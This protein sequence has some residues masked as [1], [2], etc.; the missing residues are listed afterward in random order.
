MTAGTLYEA[1]AQA[2]AAFR[3]QDWVGDIGSGF[4]T[5]TVKVT[6]VVKLRD[7]ENWLKAKG[8][9]PITGLILL[10]HPDSI[11]EHPP[12]FFN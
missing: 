11:A 8:R 6:H 4:T 1:V 12:F 7:F 10:L 9:Y 3:T 2:L 5:A